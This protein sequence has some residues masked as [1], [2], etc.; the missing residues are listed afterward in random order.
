[1]ASRGACVRS[2]TR[3][4]PRATFAPGRGAR[5]TSMPTDLLTEHGD[6][7]GTI[8]EILVKRETIEQEE[9]EGLLAGKTEE[10]VF[11]SAASPADPAIPGKPALV[12]A[13]QRG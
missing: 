10:D 7:S 4:A 9:F 2:T 13:L 5:P 1:M 3:F 8:S 12:A 6:S 11:G